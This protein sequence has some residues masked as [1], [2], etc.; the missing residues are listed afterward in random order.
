M[1]RSFEYHHVVTFDETN[2]VGNVYFTSHLHWQGHCR[3]LFLR[4]HVP[5]IVDALGEDLSLVTIRCEMEY[6]AELFVF[7]EIVVRMWLEELVQNRIALWF[8]YERQSGDRTELIATGSQQIACMSRRNGALR[9]VPVPQA[10]ADAL[11]PYRA[12]ESGRIT[13]AAVS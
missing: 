7:D 13:T 1:A 8:E 11:K 6:R 9:A 2:V 3:E 10:L 5:E 4:E 12:M